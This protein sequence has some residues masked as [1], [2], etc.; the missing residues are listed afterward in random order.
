MLADHLSPLTWQ[1]HSQK[2]AERQ[3]NRDACGLFAN[4]VTMFAVVMNASAQGENGQ[5][6]NIFWMT[7]VIQALAQPPSGPTVEQVLAHMR[8]RAQYAAPAWFFAGN[9]M[10]LR[11]ADSA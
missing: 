11:L 6:F 10:L 2:G 8:H 9:S 5:S 4:A 1:W 3:E 7:Q